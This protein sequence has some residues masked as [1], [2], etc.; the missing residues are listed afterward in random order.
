MSSA[1]L[2]KIQVSDLDIEIA[3]KSS[4]TDLDSMSVLYNAIL[5]SLQNNIDQSVVLITQEQSIKISADKKL[6]LFKAVLQTD[7]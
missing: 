7:D 2:P 1:E 5:A 4:Q 3:F 6:R